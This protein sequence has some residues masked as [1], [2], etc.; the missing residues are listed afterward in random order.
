MSEERTENN[1]WNHQ[2]SFHQQYD[3][4]FQQSPHPIR[5][6]Q[7]EP[8]NN[9]SNYELFGGS[10]APQNPS[11]NILTN[12]V[13]S[14]IIPTQ[15]Q[16][17][18]PLMQSSHAPGL[19]YLPQQQPSSVVHQFQP[20]RPLITTTTTI[21][22][23]NGSFQDNSPFPEVKKRIVAEVKPMRMSYSD[24]LSKS[25]G[26]EDDAPSSPLS[27]LVQNKV[28]TPQVERKQSS[29]P[30]LPMNSAKPEDITAIK[31]KSSTTATFPKRKLTSSKSNPATISMQ[32]T[33]NPNKPTTNK[34]ETMSK[35]K[36]KK[37]ESDAKTPSR[38]SSKQGSVSSDDKEGYYNVTKT[39]KPASHS[40][41]GNTVSSRKSRHNGISSNKPKSNKR[42]KKENHNQSNQKNSNTTELL[43][44]LLNKILENILKVLSWLFYLIYDIVVIGF[45]MAYERSL[46]Y[47]SIYIVR[48]KN[49][50]KD[51][52]Q[53][54][55]KPN[56]WIKT[57]WKRFDARFSKTSKWAFWRNCYK[58]KPNEPTSEFYKNGRLPSTAEEAMYSLLNCKGKDA[59]SILGV[60]ADS[61]Q[62]QIRKH[63]K[64]IA[65]LVHPD[66]NKQAGAEE[67]FKVLRRAFELVGEPE[68]RKT[69]DRSLLEALNAEKAWSEL[70]D[71]LSQL[72][73]KISEAA[74]TIRCSSCGSRHPR[75][76]T[77]RAQYAARECNSCKI[78]H[79]AKEVSF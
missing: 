43:N 23:T 66:K 37:L 28:K 53:N 4:Q 36:S 52:Q 30:I 45:A 78:R 50:A 18:S 49:F 14:N 24:V 74:N 70:H 54:S 67:A 31:K 21:P 29:P 8:P 26:Q 41:E 9:F 13:L 2:Q 12:L 5:V 34:T 51:I 71:L 17:Q 22:N 16:Q 44:A 11:N 73:T 64:K 15:Y 48:L 20:I 25:N 6:V 1:C 3:G 62:E 58:K 79:P 38:N 68:S 7:N 46:F 72:Q 32:T 57:K 27:N 39:E 59:Y 60:T 69:Y 33:Q 42:S 61:S 55:D 35:K 40:I 56:I 76:L 65:V 10:P 75:K 77:D 19:I 63:Y 47:Y